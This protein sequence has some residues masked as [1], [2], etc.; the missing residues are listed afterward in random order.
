LR[1]QGKRA[2]V[3]AA[4]QGIGRAT[5]I[6]FA[7][8]GARVV[9]ADIDAE[10]LST[11]AEE[12]LPGLET[13]HLDVTNRAAI[14]ELGEARRGDPA[15]FNVLF[16]CAGLV[17]AGS[18]LECSDEEW[19]AAWMV[20]V[21][22]MFW[23][24]RAL[25]PAMVEAGGGSIINVASIASS[26][27]SVPNRCAY[28]TTKAAVIGLTKSIAADFVGRGI[29]CNAICPGTVATPS[30]AARIRAQ[31][32]ATGQ[33]PAEVTAAFRARQPM[34]RFGTPAEIAALAVYLASDEATFTT[35][36]IHIADGGWTG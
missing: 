17:H 6:A 21:N 10:A 5:A 31:A 8:A 7:G 36:A 27:K 15:L 23:L 26:V 32:D 24:C 12:C 1:L 2:L 11:L 3:T 14:R 35:G 18:V 28:S 13:M 29:R 9:A 30:L 20:N 16:N 4:G 25:L 22:S 34:G 19:H 33:T